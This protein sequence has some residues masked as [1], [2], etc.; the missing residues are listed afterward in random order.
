MKLTSTCR[1]FIFINNVS[2]PKE[3]SV[4]AKS[5]K[6]SREVQGEEAVVL[7]LGEHKTGTTAEVQ[8]HTFLLHIMHEHKGK[9]NLDTVTQMK[10][11]NRLLKVKSCVKN[12]RLSMHVN[13]ATLILLRF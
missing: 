6:Q 3:Q 5:P 1:K 8:V 12:N 13:K 7:Q 2:R 9:Y 4:Q 11:S 10:P